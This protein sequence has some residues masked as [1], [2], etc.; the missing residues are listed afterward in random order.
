[1]CDREEKTETSDVV[2]EDDEGGVD[3]MEKGERNDPPDE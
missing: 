2:L 3:D 1:V